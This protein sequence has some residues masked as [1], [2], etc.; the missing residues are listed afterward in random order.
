MAE[1]IHEVAEALDDRVAALGFEVVAVEW[2]GSRRRPL[3]RLRID[4]V[5]ATTED[6]GVTV[7]D[8]VTVSRGLE[9]WLDALDEVPE[10]YVL[11]V[12]SPGVDRPLVR[13]RDFERFAGEWVAVKGRDVLA[14]RARRLEGELVGLFRE[15]EDEI[16]RLRLKKGE[17]VDV[18]RDEIVGAHI[19]YRWK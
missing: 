18:P 15:G 7:D 9:P 10:R 4:R 3:I 12:S 6:A 1:P 8:C 2:A 14:A 16:V 19:I 17:E 11:E 5:G 13:A